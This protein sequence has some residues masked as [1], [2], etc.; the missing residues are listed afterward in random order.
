MEYL[1]GGWLG[2]L[3]V[4]TKSL[5]TMRLKSPMT[6]YSLRC[7]AI[8]IGFVLAGFRFLFTDGSWV[9]DVD[10]R[11]I[12]LGHLSGPIKINFLKIQQ[13]WANVVRIARMLG[14]GAIFLTDWLKGMN[15][16][17]WIQYSWWGIYGSKLTYIVSKRP[18]PA[19]ITALIGVKLKNYNFLE[20]PT[21]NYHILQFN[22]SYFFSKLN[23][24]VKVRWNKPK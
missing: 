16:F 1:L 7:A 22:R 21:D 17:K 23:I 11:I 4:G 19:G 12:F 20:G 3:V 13:K 24:S 2:C 15:S 8:L 5:Q 10:S 14:L 9:R 18:F 6:D